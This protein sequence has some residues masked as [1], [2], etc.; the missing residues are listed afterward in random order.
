VRD[1][2]SEAAV[3][4]DPVL[5]VHGARVPGSGRSICLSPTARSPPTDALAAAALASDPTSGTRTPPA[6]R[7]P[8]GVLEDSFSHATG[9]RVWDA[10]LLRAHV[11]VLAGERDLWSRRA[12]RDGIVRGPR[13][14]DPRG[15]GPRRHA[16]H[17]PRPPGAAAIGGSRR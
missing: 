12:D 4:G 9:R 2:R 1:V 14:V 15:G 8:T 11:L 3:V 16:R 6:F 7:A 5:L 17:A 13:G 10:S